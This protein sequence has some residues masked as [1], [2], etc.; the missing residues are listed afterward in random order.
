M[1]IR[2]QQCCQ[3]FYSWMNMT[4]EVKVIRIKFNSVH[5]VLYK[6]LLRLSLVTTLHVRIKSVIVSRL[7]IVRG[8]I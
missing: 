5:K 8:L 2:N 7:Y 1:L 6:P 4:Q 3:D